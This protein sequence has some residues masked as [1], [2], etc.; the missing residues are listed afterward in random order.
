[1]GVGKATSAFM[2]TSQLSAEMNCRGHVTDRVWI[3]FC[4][5]FS[6][7]CDGAARVRA[8]ATAK[9]PRELSGEPS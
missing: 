4:V 1:M 3:A 8:A 7:L 6:R 2:V 5:P 9:P